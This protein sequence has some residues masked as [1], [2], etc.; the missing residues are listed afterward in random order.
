MSAGKV[1]EQ[2]GTFSNQ[3]CS[4]GAVGIGTH[5]RVSIPASKLKLAIVDRWRRIGTIPRVSV[6]GLEYLYSPLVLLQAKDPES[7]K[8]AEQAPAEIPAE[9]GDENTKWSAI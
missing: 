1:L 3:I 9:A 6:L 8:A 5:L 2:L 4:S 7:A